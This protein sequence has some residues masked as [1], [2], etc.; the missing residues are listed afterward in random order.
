M[1]VCAHTHTHTISHHVRQEIVE[2]DASGPL[3]STVTAFK[4][5][6]HLWHMVRHIESED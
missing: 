2:T 3:G 6:D 1:L 5:Y 4:G